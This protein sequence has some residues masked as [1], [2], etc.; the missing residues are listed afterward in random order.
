MNDG[1]R[2]T[3]VLVSLDALLDTRIGTIDRI[4]PTV[5]KEIVKDWYHERT[6]DRF[7]REGTELTNAKYE[8]AYKNRDVE[9]IGHSIITQ[10][11]VYLNTLVMKYNMMAGMPLDTK[12]YEVHVNIYPYELSERA[13]EDLIKVMAEYT[14]HLPNI[15]IV[16]IPPDELTVAGI[17]NLYT[18][19]IMYDF[20]EWLALHIDEFSSVQVPGTMFI[21]P[22]LHMSTTS[23]EKL[24]LLN[25]DESPTKQFDSEADAF[26][27]TT[28]SMAVF[29]GL[30]FADVRLFSFITDTPPNLDC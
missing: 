14:G 15:E 10:V 18:H 20:N 12:G 29:M 23:D 22:R 17:R 24:K 28:V 3:C 1:I 19:I 7:G 13:Q 6:I 16:S 30:V 27:L 21:V 5:G 9:T 4:A 25:S 2:K 8:E 11:P 26:D